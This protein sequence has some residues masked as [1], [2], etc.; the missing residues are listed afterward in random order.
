M[1]PEALAAAMARMLPTGTFL[2]LR[3]VSPAPA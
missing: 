1:T 2:S 3:P